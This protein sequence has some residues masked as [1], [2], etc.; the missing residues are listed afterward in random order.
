METF[1][2]KIRTGRGVSRI[3]SGFCCQYY[4]TNAQHSF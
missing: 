2:V 3:T 4:S 1:A